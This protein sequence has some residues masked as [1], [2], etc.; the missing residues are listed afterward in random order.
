TR[1]LALFPAKLPA[2]R[3]NGHCG[4]MPLPQPFERFVASLACLGKAGS[5][6]GITMPAAMRAGAW[7]A[8]NEFPGFDIVRT[9]KLWV[10]STFWYQCMCW[11]FWKQATSYCDTL[12]G[13]LE[14]CGCEP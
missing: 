1:F 3:E 11:E 4:I 12:L 14:F 13:F 7:P 9:S 8:A 6:A 10:H 2:V 5:G